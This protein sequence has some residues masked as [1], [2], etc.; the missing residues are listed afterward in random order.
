MLVNKR[1][2]I[3]AFKTHSHS[4]WLCMKP[5]QRAVHIP[6]GEAG[7]HQLF[8]CNSRKRQQAKLLLRLLLMQGSR[9][10]STLIVSARICHYD[11]I[12]SNKPRTFETVYQIPIPKVDPRP[13]LLAPEG[14]FSLGTKHRMVSAPGNTG[15]CFPGTRGALPKGAEHHRAVALPLPWSRWEA[16][17]IRAW[18]GLFGKSQKTAQ[19]PRWEVATTRNG[20]FLGYFKAIWWFQPDW[21]EAPPA[22]A[23]PEVFAVGIILKVTGVSQQNER[24]SALYHAVLRSPDSQKLHLNRF[25][26]NKKANKHK[27]QP[28][29]PQRK[30]LG[31]KSRQE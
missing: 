31:T 13:P 1:L 29:I 7:G 9:D 5:T 18:D 25:A 15:S 2:H 11:L 30:L 21:M 24:D 10:K 4:W 19:L 12:T 22:K 8:N 26:E 27:K 20:A 28:H 14:H 16:A 23:D 17:R 3:Q 6:A